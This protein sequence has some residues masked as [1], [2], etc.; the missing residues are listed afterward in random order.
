LIH[1]FKFRQ[2]VWG[3]GTGRT[4]T[5]TR[6]TL[7]A[8]GWDAYAYAFLADE[9]AITRGIQ[10]IFRVIAILVETTQAIITTH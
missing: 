1:T 6:L 9:G 5:S 7:N 2:T 4:R 3:F 10:D 8:R